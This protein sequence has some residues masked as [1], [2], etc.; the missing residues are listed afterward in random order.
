VAAGAAARHAIRVIAQ[1]APDPAAI[2]REANGIMLSEEFG[3]QFVTA[4]TAHMRWEGNSLRVRL[5]CA[6]HPG[7][8]LVRPDG[9]AEQLRGG[10]LP[11]GIFPDTEPA[12][13]KHDLSPGDVLVFFTD[14][15]TDARDP[16]T[17][18]FGDRLTAEVGALAGQPPTRM[19]ARLQELALQSCGGSTRDDITILALRVTGPP[20]EASEAPTPAAL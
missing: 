20:A 12:T 8:V 2:L 4:C 16:A 1:S 5:G 11:L 19:L 7:P 9:R 15:L 18:H 10:G 3:S 14:G 6:G 13:E 17:G